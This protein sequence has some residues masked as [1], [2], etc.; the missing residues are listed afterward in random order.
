MGTQIA[1][2][3]LYNVRSLGGMVGADG[4]KVKAGLL[5]RGDRL[6]PATDA[7]KRRL[8]DLGIRKIIDF[9][10][11]A[12]HEERPDPT[13][14]SVENI[15]LPIIVDVRTG[16]TRGKEGFASIGKMLMGGAD[17]DESTVDSHMQD[18]YRKFVDDG[19]SNKQYARFVDEV[20]ASAEKGEG[21]YW[22]C[23]A[24][25]DRAG[26]AT[27]IML[28]I[29]GVAREEI[30]ADYLQTNECLHG[31]AEGMIARLGER[32]PSDNARKALARFLS[33]DESYMAA[34]Y[35]QVNQ[36]FGSFDAFLSEA[37]LIDDSKKHYLQE[38][39]LESE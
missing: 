29:L 33:A 16:I 38:L 14:A 8:T 31:F 1:F 12:E 4:R 20:L 36:L 28:E 7:D 6:E 32:L 27:V 30:L 19:F 2:E 3:G 9:R 5:Y 35:D 10:S 21:V 39:L 24:G 17:I 26:F 13:I 18:M 11:V 23:T 15:F 37:L 25:K 34:A 22:H